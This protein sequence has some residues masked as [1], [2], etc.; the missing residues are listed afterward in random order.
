MSESSSTIRIRA[1]IATIL[2][3]GDPADPFRG[4]DGWLATR[5]NP[6]LCTI[7]TMR[8][9]CFAVLCS[10]TIV[11]AQNA[12]SLQFRGAAPASKHAAVTT[13][14]ATASSASAEKL[15]LVLEMTPNRSE[16]RRVGK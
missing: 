15:S 10:S 12:P 3:I 4:Q 6:T 14:P 5:S 2:L 7:V 13:P 11:L 9:V 8:T 16:E 1:G